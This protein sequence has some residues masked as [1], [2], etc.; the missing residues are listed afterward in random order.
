MDRETAT[1]SE[2]LGSL[3]QVK[4]QCVPSC[5][6]RDFCGGYEEINSCL[7]P[8]NNGACFWTCDAQ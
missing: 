4:D 1:F 8:R 6:G 3:E 7:D 2:Y 5:T